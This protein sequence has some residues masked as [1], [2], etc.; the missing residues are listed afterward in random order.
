MEKLSSIESSQ[1]ISSLKLTNTSFT[2]DKIKVFVYFPNYKIMNVTISTNNSLF[3]L[4]KVFKPNL[5]YIYNG[6]IIEKNLQI[7]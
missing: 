4:D 7:S 2:T 1:S 6:C 5:I 3:L